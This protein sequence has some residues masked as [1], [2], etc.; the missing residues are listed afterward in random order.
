MR[1]LLLSGLVALGALA[2][3]EPLPTSGGR[4]G[5]EGT[6]VFPGPAPVV[7]F[8]EDRNV[9][10]RTPLPNWGCNTPLVVGDRVF[11]VSEYGWG[12]TSPIVL[13][14][15]LADGRILWRQEMDHLDAL[16]EP[17]RSEAKG[18]R[19][20]EVAN[21]NL[22]H[23]LFHRFHAA[24]DDAERER[25][26]A[27]GTAAGM[28]GFSRLRAGRRNIK[29]VSPF[30]RSGNGVLRRDTY[31][32]CR[33][34][35][36]FWYMGWRFYGTIFTGQ[37]FPSPVSDGTAIYLYNAFGA[38]ARYELDGTR[39]WLQFL[40]IPMHSH[41]FGPTKN[42]VGSPIIVGDTLV[43]SH[44]GDQAG[45]RRAHSSFMV[46][47]DLAT[48]AE[49]WRTPLGETERAETPTALDLDGTAVAY[50]SGHVVRVADGTLLGTLEQPDYVRA[51]RGS[52]GFVGGAATPVTM[53]DLLF[54]VD[55]ANGAGKRG[56]P[57][58]VLAYRLGVTGDSLRQE[59]VWSSPFGGN[60]ECNSCLVI[61][62]RAGE[63]Y[64]KRGG[65]VRVHDVQTGQE[66]RRFTV[67]SG[68]WDSP[69]LVDGLL[70]SGRS[71]GEGRNR[72]TEPRGYRLGIYDATTG[73][74]RASGQLLVAPGEGDKA[75]QRI[76]QYAETSWNWGNALPV[77]WQ[78]R[79][80]LRSNDALYCIAAP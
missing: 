35:R 71:T 34:R 78:G 17:E 77:V 53:G 54:V 24:E 72:G 46:G 21:L 3:G 76:A 11:V 80:L 38:V 40:D 31:D 7:D 64:V 36:W 50:V 66:R 1:I 61:D 55:S 18:W 25:V 20:R 22:S 41:P 19:D 79:I 8:A 26:V 56:H 27:E 47:F 73:E 43:V 13:C 4:R 16:A 68:D 9:L 15:S 67:Q 60:N 65:S 69:I 33:D 23:R 59:L 32:T 5:P 75:E 6:G 2:A 44:P 37:S 57:Y 70:L 58:G 49:R 74:E 52:R 14:L 10:W 51:A 48:G 39:T 29:D 45:D 30:A 42:I 12:A 62:R 28:P 63:L